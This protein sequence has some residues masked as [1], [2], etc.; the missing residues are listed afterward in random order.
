[1]PI[2]AGTANFTLR[3]SDSGNQIANQP[4]SITVLP[5]PLILRT[6]SLPEGAVGSPYSQLAIASGG[7]PPYTWSVP[8]GTLPTGLTLYE[9]T[10]AITGTPSL[11]GMV[12]FMLRVSDGS[13]SFNQSLS[14]VISP[15]K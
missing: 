6:Q 9:S 11:A 10:G 3:V 2:K 5:A 8:I 14:I 4:M 12:N 15:P 13:Q 7:T 1:V